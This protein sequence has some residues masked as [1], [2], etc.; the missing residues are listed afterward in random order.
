MYLRKKYVY[1][2]APRKEHLMVPEGFAEEE[3]FML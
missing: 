1:T 2:G 3:A